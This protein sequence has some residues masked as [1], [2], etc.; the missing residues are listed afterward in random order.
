MLLV[1]VG[2]ATGAAEERPRT[3]GGRRRFKLAARATRTRAR[4]PTARLRVIAVNA[5]REEGQKRRP[6][7]SGRTFAL[8]WLGVWP[9]SRRRRGS[10]AVVASRSNTSL[11]ADP[12]P[13]D[14]NQGRRG[15]QS[16]LCPARLGSRRG[17]PTGAPS[18]STRTR[19]VTL[20]RRS[21]VGTSKGS[22]HAWQK[23]LEA[24]SREA[25][26]PRSS[27]AKRDGTAR[28]DSKRR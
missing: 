10:C 12:C 28:D 2:S 4:S 1:C 15:L 18:T 8:P 3:V 11:Q 19:S 25:L 7:A 5:G 24:E 20:W 6:S 22:S 17:R 27:R 16:T 9:R 23:R 14:E 26:M 21:R 13:L